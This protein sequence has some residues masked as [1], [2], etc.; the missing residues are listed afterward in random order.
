MLPRHRASIAGAA[1]LAGFVCA[2]GTQIDSAGQ[3][4]SRPAALFT[5]AQA[6]RGEAV[7]RQSCASCHGADIEWRDGARVDGSALE[8]SWSDPRITL[9][10][11]L[12][13]RATTMPPR[14]SNT[15]SASRSGGGVRLHPEE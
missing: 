2:S 3:A 12:R 15:M 9:D 11:L 14:A 8:A 7:Y 4:A 5:E 6:Q 10:D 13:H 1:L